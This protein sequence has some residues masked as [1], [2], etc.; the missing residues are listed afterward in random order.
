M[1]LFAVVI[2][3]FSNQQDSNVHL[4]SKHQEFSDMFDKVKAKTLP[5]HRP[6]DCPIDLQSKKEPPWRSI[7][8]LPPSELKVLRE[9]IDEN[10]GNVFIQHSRSLVDAPIFFLKKK[11]IVHIWL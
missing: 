5:N 11:D 2:T 3:S 7:Y 9:Y 8:N 6:Y 4:P 10:L 1:F